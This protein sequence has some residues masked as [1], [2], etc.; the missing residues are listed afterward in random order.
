M[1]IPAH[2]EVADKNEAL[3]FVDKNAF[4]QLISQVDG[5][6]FSTH[7]PFLLAED[8]QHLLCH[9]AN[10]NPQWESLE[11]QE[12]LVSLQGPHAYVSP[13]W[14]QSPGVPTWNYQA[15]H[16]YGGC[17]VFQDADELKSLVDSLT[18]KYESKQE[19]PWQPNYAAPVLKAIVGIEVSISEIQCKYKLSQ[20]RPAVDRQTVIKQLGDQVPESV[21]DAMRKVES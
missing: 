9:V 3:S 12:V 2:F 20:N 15:V 6:L 18:R 14:Y 17:R 8:R 1:Y 5:R 4:G 21:A 7:L 10:Q 13:G 19:S 11:S 16:I